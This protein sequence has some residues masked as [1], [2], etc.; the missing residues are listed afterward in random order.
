MRKVFITTIPG[1]PLIP[2]LY[3]NLGREERGNIMFLNEAFADM[4]EPLVEVTDDPSKADDLLIPHNFPSVRHRSAYLRGF[5]ELSRK[6]NKRIVVIAHGDSDAPVDLPNTIVFRTSLYRFRKRANEIA[7]PAYAV[8][9]LRGED[10]VPRR[11]SSLPTVGFCGW[12]YY[13]N[14]RNALATSL[15]DAFTDVRQFLS[16]DARIGALKK[17]L[18][19]RRAAVR[20]LQD[21]KLVRTNFLLRSSYSGH[22]QTIRLDPVQAREEYRRNLLDSD[23]ALAIKGDGNYSYRFYEALSLGRVPLFL[24][25]EC[26]LPLEDHLDYSAFIVRV[27]LSGLPRID[28]AAAAFW[29]DCPDE[30]FA[31]MQ[32]KAREA[33][34][35]RLSVKAFFRFAVEKLL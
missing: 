14:P 34:A 25:T 7:M 10:L 35:S 29:R 1:V 28:Q 26:V 8:D 30:K 11:K 24:D 20:V 18:T 19:F 17:G 31:E 21:S 22:L 33:F 4:T 2:L 6:L 5:A 3:P 12:V 27:P 32:R 16:R 13:K 23:L 9:L 15:K